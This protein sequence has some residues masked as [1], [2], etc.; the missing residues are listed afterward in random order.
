MANLS[1]D[2][3]GYQTGATDTWDSAVNNVT[4]HRAEHVNGLA[5]AILQIEAVLGSG[6]TLPGSLATLAARL[7][8]QV[9][10]D[11]I[12]IPVGTVFETYVA[13]APSGWLFCDGSAVSRTTY[14]AL[15][16][17]I[18]TSCGAGDGST[19]FN[20]PD[21]RGRVAI[22]A[23]TGTGGGASGTGKPTG[24][25][26]LTARSVG[27]WAG[28]ETHLNTAD[29]SGVPLHI[30]GFSSDP[31][32]FGGAGNTTGAGATPISTINQTGA[33]T[34]ADAD[35]AHNNMQPYIVCNFIIKT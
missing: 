11:G 35:E 23:G 9:G 18:G 15:F 8:V 27:Q 16:T 3:S 1:T 24:G 17:A 19:T 30:H 6:A 20:V 7:A 5:S 32:V 14:S 10:A 28:E 34:A 12:I 31:V 22:G 4:P 26:A 33:G 2:S 25:D 13:S 21:K 29:E